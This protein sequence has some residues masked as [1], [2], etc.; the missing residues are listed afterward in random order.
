MIQPSEIVGIPFPYTDMST[1]KRRPV[2]VMTRPD[3]RDDFIG[4][5]VTSVPTEDMAVRL[6]PECMKNG[7]LPKISWVRYD[8]IFTLNISLVK[9]RYGAVGDDLFKDIAMRLCDYLGCRPGMGWAD[10]PS[11]EIGE[12]F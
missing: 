4:L 10:E 7:K 11:G 1:H 9:T 12:A 3:R 2:L 8:K 6:R 5:A